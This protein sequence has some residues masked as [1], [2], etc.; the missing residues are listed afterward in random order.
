[1]GTHTFF[2]LSVIE[3]NV[4]RAIDVDIYHHTWA[5]SIRKFGFCFHLCTKSNDWR[6]CHLSA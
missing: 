2:F 6:G 3:I 4:E 1:M 5:H